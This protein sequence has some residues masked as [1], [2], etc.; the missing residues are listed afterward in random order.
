METSGNKLPP[1]SA[2]KTEESALLGGAKPAG[3]NATIENVR[4][5][6][7]TQKSVT[8]MWN[9]VNATP[10]AEVTVLYSKYGEK[11]LLLL[12]ADAS[13]NQV[14][15]EGLAPGR[16]YLACVCLKGAS[17]Q[18]EQCVTFATVS[19][20]QAAAPGSL[21][22]VLSAVACGIVLSLIFFL[23]YKVC[24][25]QCKSDP[26]WESDWA[27]ETYIQFETLSPRRQSVGGP[28]TCRPRDD[29]EKLLLC[30]RSSVDSQTTFKS[31][32]FGS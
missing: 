4:V 5:A 23:L 30:S 29:C 18:K 7:Q 31:D 6:G 9:M 19:A 11:D 21:F 2:S 10:H 28:W 17:P 13:Q 26:F 3:T 15:L 20:A 25:L 32:G 12:N 24:K 1:A 8:L 27:K 14:T 22:L 16:Q